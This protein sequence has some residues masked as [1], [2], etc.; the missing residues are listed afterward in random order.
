MFYIKDQSALFMIIINILQLSKRIGRTSPKLICCRSNEKNSK[1]TAVISIK[2]YKIF[3]TALNHKTLKIDM[4]MKSSVIT[5]QIMPRRDASPQSI[6]RRTKIA[7][8]PM[9][10]SRIRG[11]APQYPYKSLTYFKTTTIINRRGASVNKPKSP[12]NINH[13]TSTVS[14]RS[15]R[16]KNN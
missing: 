6:E 2:F 9:N 11:K 3:W 12:E 4:K 15:W 7:Q 14:I 8:I 10:N 1:R 5:K 13:K 16:N